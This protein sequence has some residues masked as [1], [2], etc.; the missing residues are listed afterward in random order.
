MPAT[1]SAHLMRSLC[2]VAFCIH[3]NST[4]FLKI[5]H[6]FS[7]FE[8]YRPFQGQRHDYVTA[9]AGGKTKRKLEAAHL[10]QRRFIY[11]RSLKYHLV[12]MLGARIDVVEA[13]IFLF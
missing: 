3:P 11:T 7:N 2:T 10:K 5:V 6:Y 1:F 12:M 9:L 13:P 4:K 8:A